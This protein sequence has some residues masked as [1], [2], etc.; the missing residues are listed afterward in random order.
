M[1]VCNAINEYFSRQMFSLWTIISVFHLALLVL[2]G[3]VFYSV[4]STSAYLL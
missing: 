3:I 2:G 1:A 4:F